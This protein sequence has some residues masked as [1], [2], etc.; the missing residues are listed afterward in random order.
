[1]FCLAEKR[2]R[3]ERRGA[4]LSSAVPAI[5]SARLRCSEIEHGVLLHGICFFFFSTPFTLASSSALFFF[6]P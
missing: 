5:G 1:M 6:F 3:S 2:L 4:R